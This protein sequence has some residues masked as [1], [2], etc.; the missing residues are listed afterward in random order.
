MR[1]MLAVDGSR[2]SQWAADLL[3]SL[4]LS[5][6]PEVT[7]IHVVAMDP[8]TRR[9]IIPPP[10]RAYTRELKKQAERSLGEARDLTARVAERLGRKWGKVKTIVEK[11]RVA[12]RI[13]ERA[14]KE[15]TDLIIMGSRGL[16][17]VRGFL[18]G[19]LS[20]KVATYAPCSVLV[21]KRKPRVF[22]RFLVAVDGSRYSDDAVSFLSTHFLPEGLQGVLLYVWDYPLRLPKR[23]I[24]AIQKRYSQMMARGGFAGRPLFVSG[25]AAGRIVETA[26]AKK[27]DLVVVGSRG[28]TGLKRFLLGGVSLGV[29]EQSPVSVLIVRRR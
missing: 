11:G 3:M 22:D 19:S 1:I 10:T 14:Q 18:M 29:M 4:P 2:H 7:V 23:P 24:E 26:R 6:R 8:L 21:V 17:N 12:A 13:I 27:S 5:G 28:L 15:K 9:L 25:D 20:H 16:G